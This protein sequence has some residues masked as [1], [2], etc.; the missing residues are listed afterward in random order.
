MFSF[1]IVG[2]SESSILN[3]NYCS[4]FK[5]VYYKC[6]YFCS[7][8]SWIEKVSLLNAQILELPVKVG[9]NLSRLYTT[10]IFEIKS[11]KFKREILYRYWA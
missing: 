5:F 8:W 10:I 2:C 1:S 7:I 9:N 4:S 11:K 3:N 6:N